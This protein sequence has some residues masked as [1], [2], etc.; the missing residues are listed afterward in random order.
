[1]LA[2]DEI[3]GIYDHIHECA[4]Q[5]EMERNPRLPLHSELREFALSLLRKNVPLS[6]LRSEC[7]AWA[8]KRWHGLP[9][10]NSSRYCLTTHDISS[11]YRSIS[12]ERGIP[13][14]TAA[15]ENLDKWFRPEK[16]QPLSSILAESCLHY[17]AHKQGETDRFE[18][19][20]S[21]PEMQAAAWKFGHNKQIL[22]DLTFGVCSA[23][24][25]LIIL[26]VI[27]DS[28]VGIPICF[29]L[30]TARESAKA[31]H[32]D[33]DTAILDR[34][35]R[36]FKER[37]GTNELG[38]QLN[39][40]VGNTDND[41]RERTALTN[42]F[43]GIFLLL[44][45]F[46]IWQAWKNGLNRYLHVIPRGEA[47]K[48]VRQHL[49]KL[50][51]KLLKDISDY[52]DAIALYNVEIHYWKLQQAKRDKICRSQAKGAL[53]FLQYLN[54]YLGNKAYW[55]SWSPAGAIIASQFLGIP[56]Q[57]VA[58]TNNHLESFN[59]RIK[60]KYYKPYQH[61]GRLPR[62]DVW[63]LL[64][65]TTVMPDFFKEQH[66]RQA[67]RDHYANLWHVAVATSTSSSSR[68]PGCG[69]ESGMT[70]NNSI[71]L[72]DTTIQGWLTDLL[73][74][75]ET[76]SEDSDEKMGN[77]GDHGSQTEEPLMASTPDILFPCLDPGEPSLLD[78]QCIS[79]SM[80]FEE[81]CIKGKNHE[82]V[83]VFLIRIYLANFLVFKFS[84][85]WAQLLRCDGYC[86]GLMQS[87]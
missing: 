58:R 63:V 5:I 21:T 67:L 19:I 84:S 13:Q 4:A 42:N 10:N 6:L 49:A 12:R 74:D 41:I 66:E 76:G 83:T 59:G 37:M 30:F 68:V 15:E 69:S 23:R 86:A 61:S 65:V 36:L 35:L 32:A 34:L 46:H 11:L 1:M 7:S 73:N 85:T 38:E 48:Y 28:G 20:L 3:S 33:Y 25:L 40:K 16:P 44:C 64:A 29:S 50:L 45:I 57:R 55:Q 18:I 22:M 39:I 87:I 81:S 2:I 79:T 72:D 70:T 80:D 43:P 52:N 77:G 9:G 71:S 53:A 26:M 56:V 51:M 75:G 60:G 8:Q 82:Q 54:S 27:D 24:A 47:R 78:P 14:R 62:I 31:V 17:Q